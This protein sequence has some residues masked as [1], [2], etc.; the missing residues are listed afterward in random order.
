LTPAL[1]EP[2]NQT[3]T[4]LVVVTYAPDEAFNS[5]ILAASR[6]FPKVIIVDNSETPTAQLSFP[7]DATISVHFNGHNA[8]LAAALN[9]GCDTAIKQGFKWAVTLDQ[10][11]ELQSDYLGQIIGAWHRAA[12]DTVLIGC[13][14][15][16]VNR[17]CYR[18]RPAR[19][20]DVLQVTTVITSGCL[21]HL[22]TWSAIGRF[23]EEYFIDA[24]DHEICLRARRAG[25]RVA[26]D[27]KPSMRH[28]IG[29]AR[30][31]ASVLA[32]IAPFSHASWRKY[33]QARNTVRTVIEYWR[34]EPLWCLKRVAGLGLDM[35]SI[36]LLE[37]DRLTRMRAFSMGLADGVRGNMRSIPWS[38]LND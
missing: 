31:Y 33:T 7:T 8:G 16:S 4:A 18:V 3:N 22:A 1:I 6:Q 19:A 26:L 25:Y 17:Q 29:H 30:S 2:P 23:R 12:P 14:Y 13:N 34:R 9:E 32:R 28:G 21:T 11:T 10:D 35:M 20:T 37:S 24:L 36:I 38:S 15:Y 5:R 27:R